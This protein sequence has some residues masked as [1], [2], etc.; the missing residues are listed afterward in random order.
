MFDFEIEILEFVCK[1]LKGKK[2]KMGKANNLNCRFYYL[3]LD[4]HEFRV[5]PD[6][7]S[8]QNQPNTQNVVY[9]SVCMILFQINKT[10]GLK[11]LNLKPCSHYID[12]DIFKFYKMT[13]F[14][15]YPICL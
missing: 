14:Q 13:A 8:K 6:L 15:F 12:T 11:G 5:L 7:Y 9:V 1:W 3:D 4:A 10:N 2:N